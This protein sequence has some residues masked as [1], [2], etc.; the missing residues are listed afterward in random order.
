MGKKR[1][2]ITTSLDEVDRS[3]YASFCSAANSLSQLY[4][5]GMNNQKFSFQA[6]ERHALDKIYQWIRSTQQGGSRVTTDDVLSYLQNELGY[7]GEEAPQS[8]LPIVLPVHYQHTHPNVQFINSAFPPSFN[9][10]SM[11]IPQ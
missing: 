6:G 7:C 9:D 11:V 4:T 2:P 5:Q 1:K 10:S 3:M 8:M